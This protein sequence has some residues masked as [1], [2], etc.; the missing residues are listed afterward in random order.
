MAAL[1]RLAGEQPV[2]R[3][4]SFMAPPLPS[5]GG[6]R[7]PPAQ[8][9]MQRGLS[10]ASCRLVPC[11]RTAGARSPRCSSERSVEFH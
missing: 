7:R 3:P 5:A 1:R 9:W 11:G 2:S 10:E 4:T 8:G 6:L